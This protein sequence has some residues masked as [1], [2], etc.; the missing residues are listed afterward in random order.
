MDAPPRTEA[1]PAPALGL[2]RLTW[3]I[4]L[5]LMLFMLMGTSDTLMLSGVSDDA[6][7]AVGV[8]NQ[9][10]ALCI[11]IMNVVS[12]GAS[13]V[14]AQY[15]GARRSA[16]AARIAAL[17]ITMNLML[18]LVVSAALLSLGDFI[19]THMNLQGPVLAHARDYIRIAGGFI[20]LQALIN[21]VSALIRTYGF[22]RQSM[23]VSLGMNVLHVVCNYALIFGHFGL[24]AW[25][26]TGAA[27][28]TGVS[29]A[30]ALVVFLWM[31]Y[32]VMDVRMVARDYV[33]FS[34]EYSRKILKVGVPAGIE[35]LTYHSCQ[36]VFLYF[37]TFLGPAALA[38]RQYAMAVS[39]YVFL[40]SLAIGMGTSILVG[41]LVGAHRPD[42]A[43]RRALESLKWA[44]TLTVLVDLFVILLRQPI[45]GL[46]TANVDILQ[47][48]SRVLLL[49]LLLESGRSFNLVLVNALRAAGDAQFAVYM[50]FVSMVCMSL[51]LGYLLVFR[52]QWGLP[53]IWLAIAADEWTRG[54]IFWLRWKSRAWEKKSLVE[55][56]EEA[57][58][59]A[60]GG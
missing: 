55:P 57:V 38:S 54:T 12:H 41:R 15:L 40:F 9:Y 16:E 17:A 48:T 42:E 23:Y 52:L 59:V 7:S 26:V 2:F 47:L 1:P 49:S 43:Y 35:Q 8:V 31:L 29:R 28:S 50:A 10:I 25:G 51:P 44:V 11:L 13:I 56:Q 21:V 19:L 34:R 5:E 4:F 45:V 33:T 53:G 30:T 22:T 58:P 39:Q 18:G 27:V 14:V 46:F 6:V 32:R 36:T 60:L 20:F 37:V 24:P 3:P